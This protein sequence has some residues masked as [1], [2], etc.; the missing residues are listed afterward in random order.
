VATVLKLADLEIEPLH[1]H[2]QLGLRAAA[3]GSGALLLEVGQLGLPGPRP[4]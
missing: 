2:R 1:V 4:L 3:G